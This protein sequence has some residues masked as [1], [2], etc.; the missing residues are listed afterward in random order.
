MGGGGTR[1]G[2]A[3]QVTNFRER[4]SGG[5]RRKKPSPRGERKGCLLPRVPTPAPTYPGLPMLA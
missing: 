5:K 4:V 3:Q 1:D 2:E